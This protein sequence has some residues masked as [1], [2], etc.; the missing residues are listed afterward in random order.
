VYGGR[1]GADDWIKIYIC[2]PS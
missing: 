1:G 2:N